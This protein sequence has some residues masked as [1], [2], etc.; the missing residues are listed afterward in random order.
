MSEQNRQQNKQQNKALIGMTVQ[1][2]MALWQLL[3]QGVKK[4]H[5]LSRLEAFCDL[6]NRHS[7]A[8][9]KGGDEHIE[10]TVHRLAKAWGWDR[11]TVSHFLT[12]LEQIGAV[13]IDTGGIRKA[14]KVN[15]VTIT[16]GVPEVPEKPSSAVNGT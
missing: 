9:L 2:D 4:S 3:L 10:G 14:V 15:N 5:K 1:T 7:F 11:V 16:K 8:A 12:N 6:L 13:T